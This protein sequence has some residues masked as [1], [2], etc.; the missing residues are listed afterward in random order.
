[1]RIMFGGYRG[2]MRITEDI[3]GFGGTRGIYRDLEGIR[4]I[5]VRSFSAARR[6]LNIRI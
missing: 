2:Y 5:W 3:R 1:M 6:W 4:G